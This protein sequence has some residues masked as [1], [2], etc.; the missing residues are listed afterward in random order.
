MP[1]Q[2]TGDDNHCHEQGQKG[3]DMRLN[4][5]RQ[6]HDCL[7]EQR[8]RG[9]ERFVDCSK[10]RQNQRDHR[11]HHENGQR[12]D[13]QRI[14]QRFLHLRTELLLGFLLLRKLTAAGFE[15]TR[16]LTRLHH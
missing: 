13:D 8:E 12:Q 5:G 9:V 1:P 2:L 14:A 15:L 7:R 11:Q 6:P 10:L 4:Q 3:E 16:Q